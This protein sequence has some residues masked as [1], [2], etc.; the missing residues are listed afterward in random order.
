MFWARLSRDDFCSSSKISL[1]F[2][3]LCSFRRVFFVYRAFGR[4]GANCFWFRHVLKLFLKLRSITGH[5]LANS[6][7]NLE[8]FLRTTSFS[9]QSRCYL[10]ESYGDF[11]ADQS[12]LV[13]VCQKLEQ[14]LHFRALVRSSAEEPSIVVAIDTSRLRCSMV[15]QRKTQKNQR[16][17]VQSLNP[18]SSSKPKTFEEPVSKTRCRYRFAFRRFRVRRCSNAGRSGCSAGDSEEKQS[19]VTFPVMVTEA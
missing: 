1:F 12:I 5:L 15:Q 3:A 17:I 10:P 8:Y 9:K 16:V 14:K 4:F 13:M 7:Y 11:Q 19:T 18:S 2:S 6:D